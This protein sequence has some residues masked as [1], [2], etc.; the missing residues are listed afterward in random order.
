LHGGI[1]PPVRL[2]GHSNY[3]ESD[4]IVWSHYLYRWNDCGQ[5][6]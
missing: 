5:D 4:V 1:S 6:C 3:I 2:P